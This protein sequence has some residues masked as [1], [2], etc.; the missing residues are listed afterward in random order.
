L[1]PELSKS[2]VPQSA[3][4]VLVSYYREAAR[5][6]KAIVMAPGNSNSADFRRA[7][8][9]MQLAQIDAEIQRLSKLASAWIEP[10]LRAAMEDG[11]ALGNRQ[12]KE[13]G[14]LPE[15]SPLAGSLSKID[16]GTP[17]NLAI[18]TYKDLVT[19][20]AGSMGVN[21]K[22]ALRHTSQTLI[23]ESE[24]NRIL[25]GGVIE[26]Q[27]AHTI[28]ELKEA[29]EKVG[30][31]KVTI[32]T[33]NGGTIDYEA[34]GYARLVARTKTREAT[35]K[36]R[37]ERLE[38]EGIHLVSIVGRISKYF[39][40]G[41]LGMVF[42]L[43]GKSDK[44]PSLDE[45]PG[46]GPPFHPNCSKSTRPFIADLANAKELDMADGVDDADKL[47]GVSA[48]EAQK[49][50]N[51]LQIHQQAKKEYATTARELFGKKS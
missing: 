15:G 21:A 18:D 37:H 48:G 50:F 32:A 3:S 43:D 1:I 10:N 22:N 14:L 2:G 27:P 4:D 19:K 7:H 29:L 6:L 30:G 36:A 11:I 39:C 46:K 13:I 38:S 35:V 41:Y 20:A 26:G 16:R 25:A 34:G 40:T 12:L 44:Y 47:V 8:G 33:K 49:R 28:R 5:R 31:G 17:S 45:L 24:I 51:S 42:S 9:A 23:T